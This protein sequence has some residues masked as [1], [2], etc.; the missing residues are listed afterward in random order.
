MDITQWGNSRVYPHVIVFLFK[1]EIVYFTS[2]F[3]AARNI[4]SS[5]IDFVY[6]LV[7]TCDLIGEI[8]FAPQ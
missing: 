8:H 5:T 4:S 6:A 3:Y 7:H 1:K 2:P